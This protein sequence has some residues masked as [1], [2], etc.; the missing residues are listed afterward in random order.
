MSHRNHRLIP[1][2]VLSKQRR[3]YLPECYF[4]MSVSNKV[5]TKGGE[6]ISIVV[7]YAINSPTL[8]AMV[9]QGRAGYV[10]LIECAD[11]Y[12][13]ERF[14]SGQTV[15]RID[16]HR[17]DWEGD[18]FLASYVTATEE[19]SGFTAPEHSDL[20]K[21]LTPSGFD[22]PV[23]AILAVGNVEAIAL[24]EAPGVNSIFDLAP[25]RQIP[26]G[27]F[28]TD[29]TG[30]RIAINL[31]PNDLEKI[32]IARQNANQ[33][34][35]LH[36][37][38]YLHALDKAVRSLTEHEDKRWASIIRQKLEEHGIS[39]TGND[40]ADQSEKLSQAIFQSQGVSPLGRMM[41]AMQPG[42]G[43]E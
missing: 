3:D 29:L 5:I 34:P 15:E 17:R 7:E 18:F 9:E 1:H 21:S 4:K 35:V 43:N 24:G 20:I 12:R 22:L 13:R 10:A 23:G 39:S 28:S 40:L 33:E 27:T 38:L 30:Q 25:D 16:L 11:T 37:S 8:L 32:N 14:I 41:D 6:G 2:P 31:H 42:G 19:I 36:Q 26:V